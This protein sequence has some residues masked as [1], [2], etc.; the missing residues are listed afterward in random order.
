MSARRKKLIGLAT[1]LALAGGLLPFSTIGL[2]DAKTNGFSPAAEARKMDAIATPKLDWY[3]CFGRAECTTVKVPL[4]YD[5]TMGPQTE[6][7][8]LRLKAR[9]PDKRI[10]SLFINPG[11]PGGSATAVAYFAP[12]IFSSEL[13]DRFDIVGMDPRGIAFSDN[14]KCFA[15]P[16]QQEPALAGRNVFFPTTA[17]RERA[18]LKSDKMLGQ[19]CSRSGGLATAMSTAEVARDMELMRRA[20]GDSKLSYFGLSY[21][22]YLGQ[23]YANMFP[24]RFRAVAIDGVLDPVAWSGT[25]SNQHEPLATRLDSAASASKALHE[26]L[27]RCDAA[28]GA[29]CAFAVGDPVANTDL[30]ARRLTANPVKVEDPLTGETFEF[31]YA[32]L[33]ANMLAMLYDPAGSELII[34]MLSSL[35]TLTEPPEKSPNGNATNARSAKNRDAAAEKLSQVVRYTKDLGPARFDFPYSNGLDAFASVTCTDSK[36][37]TKGVDFPSYAAKADERAKYFGRAW[38]WQTSMC[39]GD[40]YTG[41]D[42]DVYTGPYTTKTASPVLIVGNF[43][44]PA[45]PYKGA[46]RAAS[47]LPNSRLVSSDS[48]GHTA[49]MTSACVTSAI[50]NYLLSGKVKPKYPRCKGDV[51]PFE[52]SEADLALNRQR[53][54]ALHRP[55]PEQGGLR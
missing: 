45:T 46:V 26:I 52:S 19:A 32:D 44:D 5:E 42:D 11:G 53:Q 25:S 10:G 33:V 13:L 39:A 38:L 20:V 21:G 1:A 37:S 4:D 30:I 17:A 24:D 9:K 28:G 41:N 15:G 22:S 47:L 18:W 6:L 34:E 27:V 35:M 50:D 36:E 49:Y 55:M 31:G 7:A 40:A 54:L 51:Q 2:A 12:F 48:F 16:R 29:G 23:V 14:V 8:L 43:Y 3:S